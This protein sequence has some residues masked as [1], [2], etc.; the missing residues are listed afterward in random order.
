VQSGAC[1]ETLDG[2]GQF[3]TCLALSPDGSRLA[4]GSWFG[5]VL[6]WDTA[7]HDLIGSFGAQ[8]SAIR[9]LS[10][11]PD[12]R[13]LAV[14]SYNGTVRLLDTAPQ[15]RRLA[16]RASAAEAQRTAAALVERS[17]DAAGGDLDAAMRSLES[18]PDL[19]PAE[20]AW[21]RKAM[22]ARSAA[23]AAP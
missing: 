4:A 14:G 16:A 12:G 6:L 19:A 11:S 5:Q 2:H 10:F 9:G 13:W 17:L 22:L 21:L 8:D 7:T 20:R 15:A 3:V 1:L 23:A 18:R